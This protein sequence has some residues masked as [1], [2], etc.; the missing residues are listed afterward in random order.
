MLSRF[1]QNVIGVYGRRH[2]D[3]PNSAFSVN[4]QEIPICSM[5]LVRYRPE[6]LAEHLFEAISV[7]LLGPLKFEDEIVFVAAT[8]SAM[9]ALG[10]SGDVIYV[11]K[12]VF[13]Y[14][15]LTISDEMVG[16]RMPA[17]TC[18]LLPYENPGSPGGTQ[19]SAPTRRA[20]LLYP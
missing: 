10:S 11:P 16:R 14:R 15:R 9:I 5:V 18:P 1:P 13:S 19:L 17:L 12:N 3:A 6:P 7:M 8:G 4:P 20:Y 2:I